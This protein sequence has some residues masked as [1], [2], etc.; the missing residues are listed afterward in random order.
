MRRWLPP[1]LLLLLLLLPGACGAPAPPLTEGERSQAMADATGHLI[2]SM[3]PCQMGGGRTYRDPPRQRPLRDC[4]DLMPQERMHGIW[5]T[6][7]ELSRFV[8]GAVSP[9][10]VRVVNMETVREPWNELDLPW[11]VSRR[12]WAAVPEAAYGTLAVRIDFLGRRSKPRPGVPV[13]TIVVDRVYSMRVL[14]TVRTWMD[15]PGRPAGF[16]D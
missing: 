15:L 13:T 16:W 6:G 4:L 2:G 5:Y 12:L 8:P 9:P 7:F 10:A 3:D 14:G 11:E 1:A